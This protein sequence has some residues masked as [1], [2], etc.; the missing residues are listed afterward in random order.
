MGIAVLVALW[1]RAGDRE[2]PQNR[3]DRNGS[4]SSPPSTRLRSA[5]PAPIETVSGRVTRASD[6]TG[7]AGAIVT[8][9][10]HELSPFDDPPILI[11]TDGAGAWTAPIKPRDGLIRA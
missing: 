8:F 1:L 11:T 10:S 5:K 4:G 7:I 2:A 9:A 3:A 6:K